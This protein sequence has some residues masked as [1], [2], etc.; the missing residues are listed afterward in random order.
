MKKTPSMTLPIFTVLFL[1]GCH[2]SKDMPQVDDLYSIE[3][4]AN[5]TTNETSPNTNLI[6]RKVITSV[7]VTLIVEN[8]DSANLHI[9]RIA[10]KFEGYFSEMSNERTTIRVKSESLDKVLEE[11]SLLGEI[12]DKN[13][14]GNDVTT[15]FLDNEIRLENAEKTRIRYL[16][17]LA[18]ANTV[19]E[20]LK[21]EK[22]LE[23]LNKTIDMIK[24][25][26]NRLLHLSSYVTISIDLQQKK[27]PGIF[28]YLFV[29][30]Y[31]S[32]KWLFVRS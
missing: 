7:G 8:S 24:G 15:E 18:K 10:N 27:K 4:S 31:E 5:N 32:V 11:I 14:Y 1:I 30:V 16:E 26:M 9:L 25:H 6:E 12:T 21:V 3:K 17:L 13:I 29:G 2:A 28:G 22:E 20:I 19:E 23:R